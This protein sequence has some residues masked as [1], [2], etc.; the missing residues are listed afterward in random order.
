[1]NEIV[2]EVT[3][4]KEGG[5]TA[6]ALGTPI[7]TEADTLPEVRRLCGTLCGVISRKGTHPQ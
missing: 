7:F 1:M 3:D 4:A 6:S 5:F 2:F